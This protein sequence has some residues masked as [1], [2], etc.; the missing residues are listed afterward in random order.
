MT[1]VHYTPVLLIC[2]KTSFVDYPIGFWKQFKQDLEVL[3]NILE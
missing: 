2:F 1:F 3:K